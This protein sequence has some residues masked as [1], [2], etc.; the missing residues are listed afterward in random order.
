MRIVD[1]H[2]GR[3]R[4][5]AWIVTLLAAGI[6]AAAAAAS[7]GQLT[8][9]HVFAARDGADPVAPLAQ[10]AAGNFYGVA[11]LG[12]NIGRGMPHGC[13]VVYRMRPDGGV[14]LLHQFVQTDGCRPDGGVQ[15]AADGNLYGT[16]L[17]GGSADKG[18]FFR[19]APDGAF[20]VLHTFG[21][22]EGGYPQSA[23]ALGRD[24][25][26]YGV[27]PA[28]G[29]AAAGCV[30]RLAPDGTL[31]VL[32][33]F[34]A[35]GA[36]GNSPAGTPV[37]AEDGSLFGTT[38]GGGEFGDGTVFHLGLDGSVTT[39]HAFDG[40]DGQFPQAL[41]LARDHMLYGVALY[42]GAWNLGTAFTLTQRGD[43]E[44]VH[45]FDGAD[46]GC[47][48]FVQPVE[49]AGGEVFGAAS[50]CGPKGGGT[51]FALS[52]ARGLATVHAFADRDAHGFMPSGLATGRDGAL[53]GTTEGGGSHQ[54]H[55]SGWGTIFRLALP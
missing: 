2:R 32:H 33:S 10:D 3:L 11:Q 50:E 51:I 31:T 13:G 12:G 21:G 29:S 14:D 7:S 44:L 6:G 47:H 36:H 53:Y 25:N 43:L 46:D 30:Y 37:L 19:I 54:N 52:L 27:L 28:G 5:A 24:G 22:A 40:D 39:L 41:M 55:G 23:L 35:D 26:F 38:Q 8:T 20:A 15:L 18:V 4:R 34:S 16:T 17:Y 42:G 48:P 49:A 9:L 45:S 1:F